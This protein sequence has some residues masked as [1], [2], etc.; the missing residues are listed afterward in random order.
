M[1]LKA[2]ERN[3]I[4]VIDHEYGLVILFPWVRAQTFF[5]NFPLLDIISKVLGL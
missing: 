3:T 4:D 5:F 2:F 1:V